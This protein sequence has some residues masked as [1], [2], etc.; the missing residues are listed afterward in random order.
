M[1]CRVIS[2]TSASSI[3]KDSI[4]N[5]VLKVNKKVQVVI[6]TTSRPMRVG[7]TDGIT[8]NFV[9][10]DK[11]KQMLADGEF[12]ESRIYNVANGDQWIY[13]VTKDSIDISSDSCYI[14]ILDVDGV[15]SLQEYLSQ[16]NI[17]VEHIFLKAKAQ[18]RLLRS[19]NRE[20]TMNDIQVMECC[21]RLID[22]EKSIVPYEEYF[23]HVLI[24]E[25]KDDFLN[26]ILKI[27]ELIGE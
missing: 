27:D 6:S 8:Y 10:Q 24:N 9:S 15:V 25:T 1:R 26:C 5:A 19:I 18:T 7:E 14:V 20:G 3:G 22:D 23:D 21:R 17:K 11:A 12:I 4:L 2:L 13:G 16:Y